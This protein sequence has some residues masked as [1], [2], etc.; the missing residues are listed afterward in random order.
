MVRECLIWNECLLTG[1]GSILLENMSDCKVGL[2][3][4]E[5]TAKNILEYDASTPKGTPRLH[6][7]PKPR[8]NESGQRT[9]IALLVQDQAQ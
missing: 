9:F 4:V 7:E 8:R 1:H 6:F 5:R 3:E 2:Q